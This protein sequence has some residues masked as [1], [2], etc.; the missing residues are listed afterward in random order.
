MG[1]YGVELEITLSFWNDL[2]VIMKKNIRISMI[3]IVL[4]FCGTALFTS[5][6][7]VL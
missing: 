7:T 5:Q 3:V 6:V 4:L 2:G 1:L